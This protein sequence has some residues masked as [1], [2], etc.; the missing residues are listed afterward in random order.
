M[1]L[2]DT[3]APD[4][5]PQWGMERQ[6]RLHGYIGASERQRR[7]WGQRGHESGG[8]ACGVMLGGDMLGQN[9]A[10]SNYAASGFWSMTQPQEAV[11][12]PRSRT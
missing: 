9:G 8:F 7:L 2:R 12:S 4:A 10:C 5:G 3:L 11:S 6:R 1:V